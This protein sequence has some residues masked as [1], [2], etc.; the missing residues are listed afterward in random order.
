[1]TSVAIHVLLSHGV[2]QFSS[3]PL[4]QLSR[5]VCYALAAPPGWFLQA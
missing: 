3:P 4:H 1:M 5:G 2:A